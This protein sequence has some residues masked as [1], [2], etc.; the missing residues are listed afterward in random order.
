MAE[1]LVELCLAVMWKAKF[2]NNELRYLTEVIYMQSFEGTDWLFL[3]AYSKMREKREIE[4]ITVKKKRTRI[5][6]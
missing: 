2:I 3:D 5:D 4:G 1:N 6:I